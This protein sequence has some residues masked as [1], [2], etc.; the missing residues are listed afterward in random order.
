VAVHGVLTEV[1]RRGDLGVAEAPGD[2]PDYFGLPLGERTGTARIEQRA[3]S[4][5]GPARLQWQKRLEGEDGVLAGP[6]IVAESE[7][8][9]GKLE[10]TLGF[11]E[12]Q[13]RSVES[14]NRD[15]PE[16]RCGLRGT[17]PSL[18]HRGSAEEE[19]GANP[20]GDRPKF[21]G[22]MPR[23]LPMPGGEPRDYGNRQRVDPLQLLLCGHR[24]EQLGDD[25]PGAHRVTL[26]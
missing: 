12:G 10:P 13:S 5:D 7:H 19:V 22:R 17:Q 3:G 21:C 8:G 15:L 11:V 2:Q 9:L 1:Q 18:G 16:W 26:G 6:G 14:S 23:L 20:F 25:R 4:I 24:T